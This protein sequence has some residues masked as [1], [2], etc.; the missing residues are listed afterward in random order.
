M[1]F[2]GTGAL[3]NQQQLNMDRM[4]K[5]MPCD[6]MLDKYKM[7]EFQLINRKLAL[8]SV[9]DLG[10]GS[11][12]DLDLVPVL[13]QMLPNKYFPPTKEQQLETNASS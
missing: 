1:V 8:G 3:F 2:V 6:N 11:V 13:E 4:D 7:L 12:L 10:S 5:C 9:P